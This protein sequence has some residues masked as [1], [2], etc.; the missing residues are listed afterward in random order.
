MYLQLIRQLA[1]GFHIVDAKAAV[2]IRVF[3]AVKQVEAQNVDGHGAIK[4]VVNLP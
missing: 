1:A 2:H 4:L 3:T